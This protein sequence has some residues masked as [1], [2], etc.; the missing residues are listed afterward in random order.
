MVDLKEGRVVKGT[1]LRVTKH[2]VYDGV[3]VI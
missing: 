2:T 1:S 3:E